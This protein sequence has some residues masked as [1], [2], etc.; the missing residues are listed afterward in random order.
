M[1]KAIEIANYVLLHCKNDLDCSINN[2]Y[3]QRLLYFLKIRYL[4]EEGKILFSDEIKAVDYGILIHE[5]DSEYKKYGLSGIPYSESLQESVNY[6]YK[7]DQL[8]INYFLKDLL[9]YSSVKL[10]DI[11]L[12]QEPWR[13]AYCSNNYKW[14]YVKA[15]QS[16]G[17]YVRYPKAIKNNIITDESLCEYF[18]E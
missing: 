9:Q 14:T 13:R 1:Y 18:L 4:I 11:I 15:Q 7:S 16:D 17:S 8:L 10:L 6:I 3:L 12:N 2:L 5:V